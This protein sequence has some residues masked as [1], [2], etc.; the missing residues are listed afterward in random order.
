MTDTKEMI[1]LADELYEFLVQSSPECT[2]SVIKMIE[3]VEALNVK[4]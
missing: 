1:E 3:R 4:P 2:L